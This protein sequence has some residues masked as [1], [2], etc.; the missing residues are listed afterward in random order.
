MTQRVIDLLEPV[1]IDKHHRQ[2]AVVALGQ[3]DRVLQMV[4]EQVAIGQTG[5]RIKIGEILD[6]FFGMPAVGNIAT[7]PQQGHDL[8]IRI[9]HRRRMGL[10]PPAHALSPDDLDLQHAGLAAHHALMQVHE[11][12]PMFGQQV[13]RQITLHRLLKRINLEHGQTRG[14]HVEQ[15]TA[16]ADQLHAFRFGFEDCA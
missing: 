15:L 12:L 4:S 1:Q 9:A 10:K 14:V 13:G 3:A 7:Y 6:A 8:P 5:Q 11:W 16:R 2:M